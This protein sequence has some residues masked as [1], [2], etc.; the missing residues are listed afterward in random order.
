MWGKELFHEHVIVDLCQGFE[1]YVL[2]CDSIE[3]KKKKTEKI[4]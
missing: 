1:S 2:E 4:V 3:K